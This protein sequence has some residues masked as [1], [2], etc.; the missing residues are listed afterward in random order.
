MLQFIDFKP[1]YEAAVKS[2]LSPFV[3]LKDKSE[4]TLQDRVADGK[5]DKIIIFADAACY[6]TENKKFNESVQ[7]ERWWLNT[8]DEWINNGKNITILCP[9]PAQTLRE[10]L[11]VKWHIADVH[12]VMVFLNSHFEGGPLR[13]PM[14]ESLRILVA[15]SEPDLMT[16]YSDYLSRA[17]HDVS[18][19]TD[20]NRC[21]ELFKKRDF[22]LVIL[23]THLIG[24]IPT[25]DLAREIVQ[26]EPS[27]KII[28]TST[29]PS[30]Y[31][32]HKLG[33]SKSQNYDILQK[34]FRLSELLKVIKQ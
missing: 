31:V 18:I 20:E 22:D 2:N 21:L 9:H 25:N 7:L 29:Y 24:N 27:Q 4:S 10:E 32:S 17:G 15:E 34:P 19:A 3:Y 8:H 1:F 14:T 5:K 13:E 23:D 33:N 26:I 11:E 30:A 6:L 16:I 28:I 12:D